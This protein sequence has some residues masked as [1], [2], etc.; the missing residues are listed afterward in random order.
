MKTI[1]FFICL[2]IAIQVQGQDYTQCTEIVKMTMDAVDNKSIGSLED[3]LAENFEIAGQTGAIA[4]LVLNQLI[5]QL[6]ATV[7]S[8]TELIK[9]EENNTLLLTYEV[10]YVPLG[11]KKASFLFNENNKIEKLELLEI[12]VKTMD[13]DT[14]LEMIT[15]NVIE[16]PFTMAGNLVL[17][18]AMLDGEKRSFILDSGA[19]ILIL[20]SKYTS[21]QDSSQ[22][23]ISSAK[24][25]GG[26]IS[27]MDIKEIDSFNLNRIKLIN[28][29]LVSIDISH[30]EE[31]LDT[32]IHGLI[33]FEIIKD[34]DLII[35]YQSMLIYLVLPSEMT[36]FL[37][38]KY[39]EKSLVKVP[40]KMEGHIPVIESKIGN[41]IYSFGLDTGAESNLLDDDLFDSTKQFCSEL[42]TD[43]L[44]GADK[45]VSVI[46]KGEINKMEI[47]DKS[48]ENVTT[49][50]S[51]I[52]HINEGYNLT[53]DGLIGYPILSQQISVLSFSTNEI[54]FIE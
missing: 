23:T 27:G 47:G 16:I 24:G 48:F 22:Q 49:V 2:A 13:Q 31:A 18:E 20:N 5:L 37:T 6:N 11:I 54:I 21:N 29:S 44:T 51:D 25:V 52:S 36:S 42:T 45:K 8:Y 17:I 32:E 39:G 53:I 43:E 35:D 14:K 10:E 40:F 7:E 30:L 33:G 15:E 1:L 26:S 41:E 19:P 3:H 9:V 12:Q 28:Q 46:N 50:Y 4:K 38:S 34:Y